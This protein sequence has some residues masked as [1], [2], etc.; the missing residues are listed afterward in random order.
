MPES[1]YTT[2]PVDVNPH[3]FVDDDDDIVIIHNEFIEKTN[4]VK[5]ALKLQE[6]VNKLVEILKTQSSVDT[7]CTRDVIEEL[8][9]IVYQSQL[10][11][12]RNN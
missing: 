8:E 3:L 10:I 9:S 12:R 6:L 11:E 1:P 5:S 7:W 4:E 2:I